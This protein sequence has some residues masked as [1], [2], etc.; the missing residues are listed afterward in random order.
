[1]AKKDDE[2]QVERARRLDEILK[3]AP[4]GPARSPHEFTQ[5]RMREIEEE[6]EKK[7][8]GTG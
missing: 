2:A 6:K 8:K 5:E 3:K 1:M 4:S 7:K